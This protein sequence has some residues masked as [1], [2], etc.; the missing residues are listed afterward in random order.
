M[1]GCQQ[2]LIK[3]FPSFESREKPK[4]LAIAIPTGV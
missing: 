4:I 2:H 1:Y 3:E